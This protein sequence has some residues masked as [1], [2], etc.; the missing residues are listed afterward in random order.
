MNPQ[1][2]SEHPC[3]GRKPP[4]GY[5][6]LADIAAGIVQDMRYAGPENFMGRPVPGYRAA[7]C[8]LRS[9]AAAAL[10]SAHEEAA[11]EGL[12]LVVYDC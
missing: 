2:E 6:R 11:A 10:Q 7:C 3:A 12:H 4:P 5:V 1:T 8:W 9:E